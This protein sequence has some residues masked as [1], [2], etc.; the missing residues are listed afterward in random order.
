[1]SLNPTGSVSLSVRHRLKPLKVKR[2]C[3]AFILGKL[4]TIGAS[5]SGPIDAMSRG[6]C[7][8]NVLISSNV[9][10]LFLAESV[11]VV[12]NVLYG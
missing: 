8:L 6:R 5:W 10:A 7:R 9:S 1:M 11:T 3:L 4:T 12:L 2:K